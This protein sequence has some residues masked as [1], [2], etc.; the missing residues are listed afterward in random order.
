MLLLLQPRVVNLVVG[1]LNI[2]ESLF[3]LES[4]LGLDVRGQHEEAGLLDIGLTLDFII[5]CFG[6]RLSLG[7]A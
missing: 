7:R 2:L 3:L 4:A 6:F 1:Q 5:L